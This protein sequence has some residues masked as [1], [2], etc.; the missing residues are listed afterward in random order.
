VLL[1]SAPI[2]ARA[3]DAAAPGVG[4]VLWDLAVLRPLG[5]VQVVVGAV[6][7]V[8]AYPAALL[9]GAGDDAIEI[10]IEGPVDQTFR[11]PLGRL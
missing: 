6:L 9:F 1:L 7:F 5:L 8:P 3:E 10:C 2:A 11:R 4:R